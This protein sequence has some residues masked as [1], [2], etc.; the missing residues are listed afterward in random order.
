MK[1]YTYLSNLQNLPFFQLFVNPKDCE[2]KNL[3]HDAPREKKN[4]TL[5]VA[6]VIA[7]VV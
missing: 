2:K 1:H 5:A 4:S 3:P 7:N 6:V